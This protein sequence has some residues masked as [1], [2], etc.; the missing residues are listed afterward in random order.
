[1]DNLLK[2]IGF[3]MTVLSGIMGL[4]LPLFIFFALLAAMVS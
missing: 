1:M 4:A 2:S 3:T